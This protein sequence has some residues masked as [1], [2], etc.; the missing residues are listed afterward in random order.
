[1]KRI[2]LLG[3]TG[4]IGTQTLDI[5]RCNSDKLSVVSLVAFSNEQKLMRQV[6]EFSPQYH[7][8]ISKEGEDCLI[9]AVKN[10]DIA[11]IATKGTA[12][13]RSILYCLDNGIDVALAN[14]EAL[15]CAGSLIMPKVGRSRLIP[16]DS[17]HCAISQCLLASGGMSV[18]KI[19]LTAS[20]GP[21]WSTP[22]KQLDS[23]DSKQAL[24]HPNWNMGT[25]ITID[26]ATMFNKALEAIEASWL[27][28]VD[29]NNI[30]IVVHRQSIV[31]SA[32]QYSNGSVIAQMANPDMRL[33]IA[34]ALLQDAHVPV[35]RLSFEQMLTLT[36]ERVDKQKFPCAML[37]HE[38]RNYYPLAATV[39]NSANDVCVESFLSG[40][41]KF[42][43][44]YKIIKK[45][46]IH[47]EEE[48]T[49]EPLTLESISLTEKK[50]TKF[51]ELLINGEVC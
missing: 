30:D 25:K 42:T 15:V 10:C 31:H 27:F 32:V 44:F 2:A 18:D 33:P 12:S 9:D 35:K 14:K 22:T 40:K 19:L 16:I 21:F 7:A 24:Q 50:A 37:G 46:V 29:I 20:G 4:S 5:V 28:G 1:M 23:V 39:M 45:S 49:C 34:Y 8:L 36:F 17:E 43:D 6:E 26:S 51:A 47:F 38:I 3:S 11:V 13:I 48:F 41:L